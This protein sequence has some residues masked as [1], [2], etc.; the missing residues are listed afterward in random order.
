MPLL[1]V[2]AIVYFI[3]NSSWAARKIEE[4][5]RH[6]SPRFYRT[7]NKLQKTFDLVEILVRIFCQ[8]RKNMFFHS[9]FGQLP[10]SGVLKNKWGVVCLIF[11]CVPGYPRIPVELLLFVSKSKYIIRYA[12]TPILVTAGYGS[13]SVNQPP[14]VL[15]LVK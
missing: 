10:P 14:L 8:K 15:D 4:T 2:R 11:S 7:E 6:C 1:V 9:F 5:E 3:L 12:S 13:S